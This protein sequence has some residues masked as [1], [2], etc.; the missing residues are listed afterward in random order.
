MT[1][2]AVPTGPEF[3]VGPIFTQSWSIY[4][5]NFP[6]FT[7]VGI[8]MT[9]PHLLAGDPRTTGVTA[10][11][12]FAFI[13][14]AILGLGG[15]AVIFYGAFEARRGRPVVIGDAIR[16]SLSRFLPLFA[17]AILIALGVG[18]GFVLFIVPGIIV[19]LRWAVALPASV[20]ENLGPLKCIRRSAELTKGHRWKIFGCFLILGVL[21]GAVFVVLVG[22]LG[23]GLP[24]VVSQAGLLATTVS[25]LV[26]GMLQ[27]YGLVSVAMIYHDLRIVKDGV[28]S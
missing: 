7:L 11:S 28:G 19:F 27:A 26:N 4:A 12:W 14:G 3:R 17:V 5:S 24:L 18:F 15:Q 21:V 1:D 20:V 2:A 8:V 23:I 9:L 10:Q 16:R 25:V 13:V 6:I 22:I